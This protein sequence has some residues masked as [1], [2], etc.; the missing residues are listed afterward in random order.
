LKNRSALFSIIP[1]LLGASAGAA[2]GVYGGSKV[3]DK[4]KG[5][6]MD[7]VSAQLKKEMRD[8]NEKVNPGP[9]GIYGTD[10][11]VVINVR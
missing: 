7:A 4:M 10:R 8:V 2:A 1:T 3:A 11:G 9:T 6:N 5:V